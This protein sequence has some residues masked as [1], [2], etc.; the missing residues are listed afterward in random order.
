M[1]LGSGSGN[2]AFFWPAG[3]AVNGSDYIY[4]ADLANQRVQVFDN[5]GIYQY[6]IGTTGIAGSGDCEFDSPNG[7]AVD[8]STGRV[9]VAD[10]YN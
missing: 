9:Y 7:V 5:A 1:T 3:I 6:T 8:Q 2:D 10:R 4:V